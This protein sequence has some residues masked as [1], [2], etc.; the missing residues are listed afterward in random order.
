MEQTDYRIKMKRTALMEC[1]TIWRIFLISI[2]NMR[3]F[4]LYYTILATVIAF[5]NR[6][7]QH[8]LVENHEWKLIHRKMLLE[9][10]ERGLHCVLSDQ[11]NRH[12]IRVV[13]W[14][15]CIVTLPLPQP[16]SHMTGLKQIGFDA[17]STRIWTG[18]LIQ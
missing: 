9:S 18:N 4:I 10:I 3:V 16:K 17:V 15:L 12:K 8:W 1:Y 6:L 14:K 5:L 7:K 11:V 13:N 2:G